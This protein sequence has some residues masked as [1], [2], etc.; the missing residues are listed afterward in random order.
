MRTLVLGVGNLGAKPGSREW[1]IAVRA[2]I[3]V[4]I[5]NTSADY[6]SLQRWLETMQR[7]NGYKALE[8]SRGRAFTSY[9]SFCVEKLPYGLGYSVDALDRLMLE[10]KNAAAV[11]ARDKQNQRPKGGDRRSRSFNVDNINTEKRPTGTSQSAALRRLRAQRPDLHAK[12]LA[13]EISANAAMIEAGFRV[14][15][16]TVPIDTAEHALKPLIKHFGVSKLCKVLLKQK[17]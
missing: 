8:D 10:R 9:E 11:D 2:R 17:G 7:H 5:K 16:I 4:A 13:N 1:A 6:A 12:V 15:T 14:K 3:Q